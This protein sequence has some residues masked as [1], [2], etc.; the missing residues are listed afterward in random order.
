MENLAENRLSKQEEIEHQ[1]G[2]VLDI[3][4][5]DIVIHGKNFKEEDKAELME[6][7]L[8][9]DTE[10]LEKIARAEPDLDGKAV[11]F[12][13][14]K[15]GIKYNSLT[16][17]KPGKSISGSVN[18]D[19]GEKSVEIEKDGTIFIDHH[20]KEKGQAHSAASI[21]YE[22]LKKE[23]LI[24]QEAWLEDFIKFVGEVDDESY[25]LKKEFFEK[26]WSKSFYG[27]YKEIDFDTLTEYFKDG[28]NTIKPFTSEEMKNGSIK[29]IDGTEKPINKLSSGVQFAVNKSIE[30]I[31]IAHDLMKVYKVKDYGGKEWL[32]KVLVNEV[33]EDKKIGTENNEYNSEAQEIMSE[34]EKQ[35]SKKRNKEYPSIPLGYAAVRANY[36][37]SYVKLDSSNG[38]FFIT[39]KDS[40]V[41]LDKVYDKIKTNYPKAKLIRGTMIIQNE[42]GEKIDREEFLKTLNLIK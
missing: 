1:I 36:F 17:V 26:E 15:A 40:D 35:A 19:T 5:P 28:R 12:L 33:P 29:S 22:I 20:A 10:T 2:V 23:N 11:I 32:G 24:K 7:S 16:Y 34:S 9:V 31:K 13:L 18:I 14:D 42:T 38:G 39:S 27:L 41:K 21:V 25:E 6:A 37:D 3:G 4:N 30:G 8:E